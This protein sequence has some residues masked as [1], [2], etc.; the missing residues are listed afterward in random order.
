MKGTWVYK[1]I[2][3]ILYPLQILYFNGPERF[4]LYEGSDKESICASLTHVRSEFWSA[5]D[6][7]MIECEALLQKKFNAFAISFI[8]ICVIVKVSYSCY[9]LSMQHYL[10]QPLSAMLAQKLNEINE[11]HETKFKSTQ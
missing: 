11:F 10:I 1:V 3:V 9:L 6:N 8:T 4:G 5:S 7:T 2:S